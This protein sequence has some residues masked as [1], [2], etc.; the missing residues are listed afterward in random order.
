MYLKNFEAFTES[1]YSV[2]LNSG[3]TYLKSIAK[4]KRDVDLLNISNYD[5][6]DF[7]FSKI[8]KD[9]WRIT[10]DNDF[11]NL[12]GKEYND[13]LFI[14]FSLSNLPYINDYNRIDF[15]GIPI[16]LRGYNLGYKLYKLIVRKFKFITSIA[17]VNTIN[18]WIQLIMDNDFYAGVN[19]EYSIVIDKDID[20]DQ[21]LSIIEVV[22]HL[23]L[24]YDKSLLERLNNL[25]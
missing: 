15:D 25:V 19:N 20:D 21:L 11:I 5:I 12:I 7:K 14:D 10:P 3:K 22:G 24:N 23:N 2:L 1:E 13:N 4:N 9:R 18:I 8:V 6:S 16:D 17:G